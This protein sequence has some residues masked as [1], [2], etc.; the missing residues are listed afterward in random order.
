M[1]KRI[2]S[3]ISHNRAAVS[4]GI[5]SAMFMLS[6]VAGAAGETPTFDLAATMT[7]S[8]Q[9]I[10]NNLLG[11]ISAVLPVTVTLLAAAIGV[12]YAI[13]FIKKIVGKAG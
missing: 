7:T 4:A 1:L 12:S 11:M 10:V 6:T 2:K 13:K 8:V 5:M 3:F 9:T